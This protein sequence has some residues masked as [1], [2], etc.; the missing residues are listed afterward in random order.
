M[1]TVT[2]EGTTLDVVI[3]IILFLMMAFQWLWIEKKLLDFKDMMNATKTMPATIKKQF[4]AA[5]REE[6]AEVD[7]AEVIP[8]D[9][10][11]T[12]IIAALF[13]NFPYLLDAYEKIQAGKSVAR[14]AAEVLAKA[15]SEVIKDEAKAGKK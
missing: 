6:L 10:G 1:T 2:L 5:V 13:N 11:G 4:K 7:W 15:G 14:E 3:I 8:E 12:S 9:V